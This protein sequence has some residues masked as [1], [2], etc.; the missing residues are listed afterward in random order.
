MDRYDI[1]AIS[2]YTH[3]QG[4]WAEVAIKAS[5]TGDWVMWQD[6][7][8][9]LASVERPE[10]IYCCL[11]ESGVKHSLCD[12]W[13]RHGGEIDRCVCPCHAAPP[14]S[15]GREA[16]AE[17]VQGIEADIRS[18]LA[19][20]NRHSAG[21]SEDYRR[22]RSWLTTE[23]AEYLLAEIARLRAA[24]RAL[25]DAVDTWSAGGEANITTQLEHARAAL[26]GSSSRTPEWQDIATAP[27]D[28]RTILGYTPYASIAVGDMYWSLDLEQW[29]R[30]P[31][32]HVHPTHWMPQLPAP[33][34]GGTAPE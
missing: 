29:E 16:Q 28:Q 22:T 24:F 10:S 17:T 4:E 30:L 6:V 7:E 13:H 31:G 5:D 20:V 27:K 12:G 34:E 19:E 1:D 33:P 8:A 18:T 3:D 32:E 14:L 9:I 15:Q 21:L 11:G 2:L 26:E 25:Y 23:Q